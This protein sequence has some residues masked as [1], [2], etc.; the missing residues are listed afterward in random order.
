MHGTF[1]NLGQLVELF[2]RKWTNFPAYAHTCVRT[3]YTILMDIY[4]A[5]VDK[6]KLNEQ[7]L[8][9]TIFGFVQH[10]AFLCFTVQTSKHPST[11][12]QRIYK[13]NVQKTMHNHRRNVLFGIISKSQADT[14]NFRLSSISSISMITT[15]VL[16]CCQPEKY[17]RCTKEKHTN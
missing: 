13:L 2:S 12:T 1:H 8:T 10:I 14:L 3:S 6:R 17:R 9:A 7:P 15:I 16:V 5:N 11:Y 4:I